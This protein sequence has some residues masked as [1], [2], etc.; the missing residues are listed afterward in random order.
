MCISSFFSSLLLQHF[1]H[2]HFIDICYCSFRSRPKQ[3]RPKQAERLR[4]EAAV[5]QETH[6]RKLNIKGKRIAQD[7]E[8]GHG[9]GI[10]TRNKGGKV[11]G[12]RPKCGTCKQKKSSCRWNSWRKK[13]KRKRSGKLSCPLDLFSSENGHWKMDL[14]SLFFQLLIPST[15]N[16]VKE[17]DTELWELAKRDQNVARAI[18]HQELI[19]FN[20][21]IVFQ[22][23]GKGT[24]TTAKGEGRNNET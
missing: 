7:S 15:S 20:S 11:R 17:M 4:A 14:F 6:T 18:R 1:A 12:E 21:K 16:D 22:F 24:C 23:S 8:L 5:K 9:H 13:E 10:G 3:S 19:Y 2:V